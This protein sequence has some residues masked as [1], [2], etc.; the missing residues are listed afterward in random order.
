MFSG[1]VFAAQTRYATTTRLLAVLGLGPSLSPSLITTTIILFTLITS[2]LAG[3]NTN[4]TNESARMLSA[5]RTRAECDGVCAR[6]V[7]A[8]AVYSHLRDE[9]AACSHCRFG[10]DYTAQSEQ[11]ATAKTHART[12][13][14]T[15]PCTPLAHARTRTIIYDKAEQMIWC[16]FV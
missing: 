9:S 15:H 3:S 8:S 14:Y 13:S 16:E 12:H 1:L 4:S 10:S 6:L 11:V 7:T 5:N 2:T